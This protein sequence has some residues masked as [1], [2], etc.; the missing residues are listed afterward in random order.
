MDEIHLA[1]VDLVSELIFLSSGEKR[2][3][4]THDYA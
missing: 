3:G 4:E 2:D 1:D